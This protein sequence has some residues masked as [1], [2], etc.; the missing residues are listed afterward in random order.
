[1]RWSEAGCLSQIVLSHAP[2]QASGSLILDVRSIRAISMKRHR[3]TK[4]YRAQVG[5]AWFTVPPRIFSSCRIDQ[6]GLATCLY[7]PREQ[8]RR[9]DPRPT[10]QSGAV[11]GPKGFLRI[12]RFGRG[13]DARSAQ[14]ATESRRMTRSPNNAM[15]RSRILVTV[16]AYA[17]PAPSIRLAHLG[18]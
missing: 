14:M 7:L 9:P 6:L 18:R 13:L 11:S 15:E 8:I 10:K 1:M 4:D 2:R 5:V 12:S 3:Q 16:R 17:R